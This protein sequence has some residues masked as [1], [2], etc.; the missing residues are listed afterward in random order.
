MIIEV[1]WLLGGVMICTRQGVVSSTFG[2]Q[3]R[4]NLGLGFWSIVCDGKK[5]LLQCFRGVF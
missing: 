2:L 1:L 3:R 5:I 4:Y